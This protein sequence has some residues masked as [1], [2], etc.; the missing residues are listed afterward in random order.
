MDGGAEGKNFYEQ[1]QNPHSQAGVPSDQ[2]DL[3]PQATKD[4]GGTT[5]AILADVALYLKTKNFHWHM[6]GPHLRLQSSWLRK[7]TVRA[8]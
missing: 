8:P 2:P 6:S 5:D 4:I 1:H 3:H 7:P